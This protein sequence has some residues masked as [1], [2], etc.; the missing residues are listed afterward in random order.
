M[1]IPLHDL[2]YSHVRMVGVLNR[3]ILPP[4]G[5]VLL[6]ETPRACNVLRVS[7]TLTE[8]SRVYIVLS[9]THIDFS[10]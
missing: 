6:H 10:C 4:F 2:Y 9:V 8:R 1:S 5:H 7:H 3:V